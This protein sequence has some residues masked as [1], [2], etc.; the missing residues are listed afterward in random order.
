MI[1]R[2]WGKVVT[3]RDRE[4]PVLDTFP[5]SATTWGLHVVRAVVGGGRGRH[6]AHSPSRVPQFVLPPPSVQLWSWDV[7][8]QGFRQSLGMGDQETGRQT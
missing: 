2:R 8:S 7:Q 3:H 6:L 4:V 1:D 5:R